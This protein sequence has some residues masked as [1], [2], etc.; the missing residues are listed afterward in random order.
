MNKGRTKEIKAYLKLNNIDV[1][2]SEG[3]KA[4]KACKKLFTSKEFKT[5]KD[6]Q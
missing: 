6:K 3:K 4:Y 2:T 1:T 5:F